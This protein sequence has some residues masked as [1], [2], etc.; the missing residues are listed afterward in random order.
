MGSAAAPASA[1]P[2]GPCAGGRPASRIT[3][4]STPAASAAARTMGTHLRVNARD[5]SLTT[6]PTPG[7]ADETRTLS[8]N[9]RSFL[10]ALGLGAGAWPILSAM[11]GLARAQAAG[12][13]KRLITFYVS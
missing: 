13:P 8:V 9:R 2:A 1:A 4:A 6:F 11:H 3:S 7:H 10:G 5:F 12:P